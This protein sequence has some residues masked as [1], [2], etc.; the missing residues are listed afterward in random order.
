MSIFNGVAGNR[1]R[2]P[3]G[4]VIHNDAGS[5]NA[6]AS[7]Y[8]SWLP[9]INPENG[10][11]HDYVC[12]D[13]T[14]HAEDD[15]NKAW[16]CG[17]SWGNSEFYSVEVCQSMGDVNVFKTNEERALALVAE[18]FKASRRTTTQFVYI[19]NFPQ[20]PVRTDQWKSTVVLMRQKHILSKGLVSL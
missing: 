1:G 9:G 20:H 8:Q 2:N 16:H 10:F 14:V 11:A 15:W 4:A 17:D 3:I 6:N 5:Q 19:R 7:Y 12:S 18:K 13:G